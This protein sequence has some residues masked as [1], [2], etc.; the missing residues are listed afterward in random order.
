MRCS[1]CHKWLHA[2]CSLPAALTPSEY[3]SDQSWTCPCCGADNMVCKLLH[4]TAE[5]RTEPGLTLLQLWPPHAH[6]A[7]LAGSIVLPLM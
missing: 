3:P 1:S 4:F 5:C 6:V 7:S 2:L